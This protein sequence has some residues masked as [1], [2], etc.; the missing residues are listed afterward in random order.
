MVIPPLLG[1]YF[2]EA[3]AAYWF[4]FYVDCISYISKPSN[5]AYKIET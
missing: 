5:A 2:T 1:T 3:L 4:I